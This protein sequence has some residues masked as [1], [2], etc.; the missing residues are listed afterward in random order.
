MDPQTSKWLEDFLGRRE[1]RGPDAR[2]LYAYRCSQEEFESLGSQLESSPSYDRLTG[3]APVRAFV[4][5]ASEWWQRRYDGGTWAWEP[6]LESIGWEH[7]HYPDLYEPV[8]RAWKWWKVELVSLP[9]SVRY[10]GTFAC[11]G[12]LPLHFSRAGILPDELSIDIEPGTDMSQGQFVFRHGED[13]LVAGNDAD[14][15]VTVEPAGRSIRVHVS[16]VDTANPPV[17]V[18]LRL[19]WPQGHELPVQA[20]FPGHGAR[21]LRDGEPPGRLLAVDDLYGVRA[22][23]LSP[24]ATQ[25]F[26]LEGELR[27]PDIGRLVRVAHFR[28][29][30]RKSGVSHELPLVDVRDMIELL[31]SASSSSDAQVVIQVVDRYQK[32]HERVR[33]SRF[34]AAVECNP[35]ISLV[36]IV[37]ALDGGTVPKVEAFPLARP[38]SEPMEFEAAGTA[39]VAQCAVLPDGMDLGEPWLLV[40]RHDERIRARPCTIGGSPRQEAMA[41][42]DG[43]RIPSLTEALSI[44]DPDARTEELGA[45][46]DTMLAK[47][48]AERTEDDWSFL[49][50]SLL[51]AESLP[52]SSLD[53]LKVL[54]TK[55]K[56]LVR[57]LF[58]LESAARQLLWRFE[59]EL[60]FSWLLVPRRTWWNEARRA[61]AQRREQLAGII[62][63]HERVAHELVAA[64]CNEGAA[65]LPTLRSIAT[66]IDARLQDE[67]LSRYFYENLEQE[68]AK[69]RHEM[70]RRRANRDDWPDDY[71]AKEW[72]GEVGPVPEGLWQSTDEHPARHP[73]LDSP[74]AAAWCCFLGNPTNR[75]TFLVKRMR[76]HD[77][78]WF[79]VAYQ[80]T[81]FRLARLQDQARNQQ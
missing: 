42:A 24:D 18:Q 19:H 71:G 21:F 2:A 67:E 58:E 13:A 3:D 50:D 27:A 63:R 34:S 49:R 48:A 32:V 11:Q 69:E 12:G 47:E 17:R 46:M 29:R 66:D 65:R 44:D 41:A 79:D 15:E 37:P 35:D 77:S 26:W 51:R 55:P 20:P 81:W 64:I 56:L 75:T 45:A 16:A 60:P 73:I 62:D 30:L 25:E 36:S 1:L 52:P 10:L 9:S 4:L 14:A 23:A 6:L 39:G 33:V 5:Y 22:I 74:V 72:Q 31:L 8:R 28:E 7:I 76:A 57:C 40:M 70:I 80:A 43:A 38:G 68:L 61:F 53:L 54:V 59:D 78:D